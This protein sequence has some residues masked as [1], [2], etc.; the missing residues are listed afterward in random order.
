[1]L[2]E[3]S[4]VEAREVSL[5]LRYCFDAGMNAPNCTS[6]ALQVYLNVA[7][8]L[9]DALGITETPWSKPELYKPKE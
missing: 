9:Q 5:M 1:M 8:K 2:V 4:Y 7:T 6:E 3:I